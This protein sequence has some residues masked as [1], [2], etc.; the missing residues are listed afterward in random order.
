MA[1]SKEAIDADT[2]DAAD[3]PEPRGRDAVDAVF[4]FLNLLELDAERLA[5]LHLR[6]PA[7]MPPAPNGAPD[8]YIVFGRFSA[9][10]TL[11]TMPLNS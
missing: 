11:Q 3:A 6:E 8:S 9:H 2:Y 5:E 10:A 7:K 4:I 1:F